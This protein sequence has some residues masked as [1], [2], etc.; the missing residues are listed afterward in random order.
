MPA[1][2]NQTQ[3]LPTDF[4]RVAIP[5]A[6]LSNSWPDA[7][8]HEGGTL[9][10]IER[11]LTECP[12][13]EAIQTLDI[14][15]PAE[16]RAIA[17]MLANRHIPHTY[18]LTRLLAE[19]HLSLSSLDQVE[20]QR[21]VTLVRAS[22]DEALET[23]A[24]IVA[25]I[26]GVRPVD[27]SRRIEALAALAD[28]LEQLAEAS[29]AGPG[30]ELVIEPLDYEAHKRN[31]LGTTAEAVALCRR[32]ARRGLPLS[33][34]LDTSHLILNGED[35]VAAVDLA[36]EFISEFHFCNPVLDRTSPLFGDQHPPFGPPGVVDVDRV[37]AIMAGLWRS[38]YL[39]ESNR[40]RVYA[41]VLKPAHLDPSATLAHCQH[42]LTAGWAGATHLLS[43]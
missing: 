1:A 16:R 17:R 30:L 28:S 22:F 20:R 2:S 11:T 39:N 10:A 9:H 40:P 4:A 34:C 6:I 29:A 19:H 41:E 14:R 12:F 38:G 13:F 31:T 37:A 15:F 18:T 5:G 23:G 3:A 36:R 32:L 27:P 21:A 25:I 8:N 43:S 42:V 7:R 33:L 24:H 35:S 26:P